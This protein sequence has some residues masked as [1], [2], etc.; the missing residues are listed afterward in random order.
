M[1][2]GLGKGNLP[3]VDINKPYKPKQT[4]HPTQLP[5]K[6]RGKGQGARGKGK[7][8]AKAFDYLTPDP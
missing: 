4:I 1:K 7:P 8:R 6:L 5:G 2:Y 3:Q